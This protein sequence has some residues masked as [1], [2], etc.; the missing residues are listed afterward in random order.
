MF[1]KELPY[2]K[3]LES[4]VFICIFSPSKVIIYIIIITLIKNDIKKKNFKLKCDNLLIDLALLCLFAKKS[5]MLYCSHI[6]DRL[7]QHG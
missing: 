7:V 1:L 3:N 2:F 6:R 4:L 5:N